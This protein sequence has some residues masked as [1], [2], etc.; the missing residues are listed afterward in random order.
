[1]DSKSRNVNLASWTF[2][3]SYLLVLFSFLG[4]YLGGILVWIGLILIFF[5]IPILEFLFPRWEIKVTP[6]TNLVSEFW[7]LGSPF[8]LTTFVLFSGYCFSI[9]NNAFEKIGIV[10]ST[11]VMTGA[12]G[13]TIAHELVHRKD[14]WQRAFGVW[15]LMLVNFGHWGIEHVF[16]HHKSVGT[17]D[18]H[19]S[20]LKNQTLYNFWSKNYFGGLLNSFRFEKK[21]I[22]G[23]AFSVFRN[24]IFNYYVFSLA[25][26]FLLV[27][28]NFSYFL[29]WWA[30]SLIAIVLLLSVDYIE[31]YGLR[32]IKKENGLY[33][34]V[35]VE[36]S[37][38][39]KAFLTNVVLFKLGFHSH[40][41]MKARLSY[42]ELE[43][44][45]QALYMPY[46]YSVMILLAMI[47]PLYFKVMNPLIPVH[48]K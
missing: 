44:Q 9:S 25:I 4:I 32:R 18:D 3:I 43:G 2:G 28:L 12:L 21:R 6:S 22:G 5:A 31:H 23:K 7:L 24:R 46:G 33:E 47:P 40:H 48:E 41:H 16:G 8:V 35:K 1:M 45:P 11:G 26:S 42:Q 10:L 15:N 36:H 39:T 17:P 37:W 29:F 30:Q 19:A 34:P 38:D 14:T 13:I 27:S 20:A